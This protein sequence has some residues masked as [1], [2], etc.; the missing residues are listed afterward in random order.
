MLFRLVRLLFPRRHQLACWE[1]QRPRHFLEIVRVL[2]FGKKIGPGE[3]LPR[4]VLFYQL[5]RE[6]RVVKNV[7]GVFFNPDLVN[8][9]THQLPLPHDILTWKVGLEVTEQLEDLLGLDHF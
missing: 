5:C 2:G 3:E 7:Y 9:L 4:R 6:S 1:N 8:Y